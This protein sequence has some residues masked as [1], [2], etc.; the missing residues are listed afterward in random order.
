MEAVRLQSAGGEHAPAQVGI[1]ALAPL[2]QRDGS[3]TIA[4]LVDL[5]MARY[6]GRDPSREQ[7]L[8]VWATKL[9]RICLAE[10]DDDHVFSALREIE[11][12]PPLY[13]CGKDHAGKPIY[14]AKRRVLA[15]STSNRYRAGLSGLIAWAIEN[16][17]TPKGYVNPVRAVKAKTENSGKTRFLTAEEAAAL[18]R[19][20]QSS[21]W[22]KLALLVRMALVTGGRRGEL[23]GLRWRDLRLDDAPPVA[24][25][26]VTKNGDPKKLVLI[27]SIVDE[28]RPLVGPPDRLVFASKRKPDVPFNFEYVW[29]EALRASKIAGGVSFHTL[30]HSCASFM[31]MSGVNMLV[32]AETLG[33]RSMAMT[34]RY[35]HIA[36]THRA[37]IANNVFGELLK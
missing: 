8:R 35:S 31:A 22:S 13:F 5:Y 1:G 9:G 19:A 33:H 15:A 11:A 32:I 37:E 20:C 6:A 17:I 2:P 10:L 18:L 12:S 25:V 28:L 36:V 14:K 29:R 27:Q 7:R 21:R 16:R 26:A 30:R 34:K 4:A 24:L 23:L 3:I